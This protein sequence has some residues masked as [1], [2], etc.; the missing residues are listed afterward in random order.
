MS[1]Y[2]HPSFTRYM[3][4]FAGG[5]FVTPP[6]F[7]GYMYNKSNNDNKQLIKNKI[8]NMEYVDLLNHFMK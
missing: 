6:L 1:F 2:K 7:I 3:K 5:L 8:S 4:V